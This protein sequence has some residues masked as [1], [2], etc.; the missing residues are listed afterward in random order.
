MPPSVQHLCSVQLFYSSKHACTA[1]TAASNFI[2]LCLHCTDHHQ[3]LLTQAQ[4]HC[5]I[6]LLCTTLAFRQL[7]YIVSYCMPC[8]IVPKGKERAEAVHFCKHHG[9]RKMHL[10]AT[11][12]GVAL[13]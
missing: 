3:R 9:Q 1:L 4:G 7:T 5:T 6:N 2:K 12:L 11:G 8:H 10:A 13:C